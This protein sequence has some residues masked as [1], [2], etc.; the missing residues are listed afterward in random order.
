[1]N[2]TLGATTPST[3]S[4]TTLTTS[5]TITHNGGTANGVAY[6][7]GSKVLTTG[8]ALV[9]DGSNLGIGTTSLGNRLSLK[10]TGGGC[11]L[12]TEDPTNTSGGNVNLFGSLGTGPAAIYT[13][14]AQPIAFY[15]NATERAR[16]GS[17][18]NLFLGTTS[19][20]I[21]TSRASIFNDSSNNTAT[22]AA[23]SGTAAGTANIVCYHGSASG[24][25]AATQIS[26]LNGAAGQVGSIT[27]TG[28]VTAYVTA[29]DYRLKN[30]VTPMT[31]A[32]AKVAA[33]KPVTYKWNAD[34]SQGQGFIAHELAEVCPDA[35]VGEKNAMDADGNP[36]YQGVDTSFLVA[37]LTAAIQ[38]QQALITQLTARITALESA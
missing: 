20:G 32:L 10:T 15:T 23:Q 13:T 35:V 36:K 5:S 4:V 11:W 38:E 22:F 2:G 12:Q 37:I 7:D 17:S 16:I 18:G 30:T 9:F 14:G 24:A 8:T 3:A 27:S 28:S 19:N 21:N 33:L 6:L 34:G 31:G 26:F 1:M 29:S 25:T